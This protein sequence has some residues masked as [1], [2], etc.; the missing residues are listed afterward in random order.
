MAVGIKTVDSD[1]RQEYFGIIVDAVIIEVS[2]EI[3]PCDEQ[4]LPD[5]FIIKTIRGIAKNIRTNKIVY[6]ISWLN[7]PDEDTWEPLLNLAQSMAYVYEFHRNFQEYLTHTTTVNS[8]DSADTAWIGTV[9]PTNMEK[10]FEREEIQRLI[11]DENSVKRRNAK[12]KQRCVGCSK[13]FVNISQHR[14]KCVKLTGPPIQKHRELSSRMKN[15]SVSEGVHS[16]QGLSTRTV[17]IDPPNE[18]SVKISINCSRCSKRFS[19]LSDLQR[20]R[21]SFHE[22]EKKQCKICKKYF[23]HYVSL[24]S[25]LG[26]A[27]PTKKTFDCPKCEKS[28][29]MDYKN[30]HN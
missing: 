25:H 19:R 29:P 24:R 3:T 26:K 4:L 20:H 7:F 5:H 23:A 6:K 30:K 11:D 12:P 13:N 22:G 16:A 21:K 28:F 9:S 15:F 17:T 1:E 14:S 10:D 2:S 8:L 27:C 18:T